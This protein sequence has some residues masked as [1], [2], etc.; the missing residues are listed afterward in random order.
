MWGA[1]FRLRTKEAGCGV[2]DG[3]SAAGNGNG[4]GGGAHDHSQLSDTCRHESLSA[5][6]C[7]L[8]VRS[9]READQLSGKLRDARMRELFE[10]VTEVRR[11]VWKSMAEGRNGG[12]V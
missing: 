5:V 4:N 10:E 2:D 3:H 1:R 12:A 9:A 6:D 8:A 11:L 7:E